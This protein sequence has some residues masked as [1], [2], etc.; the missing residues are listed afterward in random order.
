MTEPALADRIVAVLRQSALHGS[1]RPV[2]L[3]QPLGPDGVGLDSL[4]LL[5]FTAALEE[6]FGVRLPDE[7]WT[8][9][10]RLTLRTIAARIEALIPERRPPSP[11]RQAPA[12]AQVGTSAESRLA[13]IRGSLREL[14]LIPTVRWV[15]GRATDRIVGKV[16]RQQ[17]QILLGIDLTALPAAADGGEVL[18]FREA[19][20]ADLERLA[21]FWEPEQQEVWIRLVQERFRPG[22]LCFVALQGDQIVAIDWVS[23]R[24]ADAPAIGLRIETRPGSCYGLNLFEHRAHRGRGAGL[25]LL[26]HVLAEA[27]R[28]GFHRQATLVDSENT[29]MLTTAIQLLGFTPIGEV[30]TSWVFGRP[31]T[32]WR[33]D[34]QLGRGTLTI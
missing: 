1:S 3:D 15:I 32:R 6:T 19:T 13:R 33:V 31:L 18:T 22:M 27:R 21:G 28:R 7:V 24:G 25:A 14:G 26:R 20:L 9:G 17:R 29:R 34:G 10:H 16:W 8:T 5:E 12:E 30:R 23:E 11:I 4:G 2:S